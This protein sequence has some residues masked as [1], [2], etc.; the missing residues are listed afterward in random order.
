MNHLKKMGVALAAT[1]CLTILGTAGFAEPAPHSLHNIQYNPQTGELVIETQ[2]Q[3]PL[4]VKDTVYSPRRRQIVMFLPNTTL[5][6]T[7]R[8]LPIQ[9]DSLVKSIRLEQRALGGVPGVRV[10][11]ELYTNSPYLPY[12]VSQVSPGLKL[13]L[14]RGDTP[15]TAVLSAVMENDTAIV[16]KGQSPTQDAKAL[17]LN[18][19]K[20]SLSF[21]STDTDVKAADVTNSIMGPVSANAMSVISDIYYEDGSLTVVSQKTPI[22]VKRSFVLGEPSRY[23]VDISPAALA[24]KSLTR[25]IPQNNPNVL[26]FKAGQFDENTVRI[27]A[28]FVKS[29]TPVDITQWE[30]NKILKVNFN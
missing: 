2:D 8:V 23:V 25:A 4:E 9:K 17:T 6:P 29:P 15:S 26:S 14:S 22:T 7:P 11:V 18:P 10:E 27:V 12:T 24:S 19:A 3:A 1:F 28:Q 21:K 20:D 16:L 13:V 5:Q 30:G